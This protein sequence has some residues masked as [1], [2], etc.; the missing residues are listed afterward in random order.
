[1]KGDRVSMHIYIALQVPL[2]PKTIKLWLKHIN[3]TVD[4][5]S[6]QLEL[7][8]NGQSLKYPLDPSVADN[9][10]L[11]F[12]APP[13]YEDESL[14]PFKTTDDRLVLVERGQPA[15]DL[16]PLLNELVQKQPIKLALNSKMTCVKRNGL[17]PKKARLQT[18][19]IAGEVQD[20]L[21][22]S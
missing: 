18:T 14:D 5:F 1:M 7:S 8:V 12:I 13:D 17:K 6:S 3:Y 4:M 15:I 9:S 11:I 22:Q 19:T 2:P 21:T 10:K 16:A 20:V